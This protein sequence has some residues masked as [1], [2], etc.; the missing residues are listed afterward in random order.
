VDNQAAKLFQLIELPIGVGNFGS[1]YFSAKAND[2]AWS[3]L[4]EVDGYNGMPD[5]PVVHVSLYPSK[6]LT[7]PKW[8][9]SDKWP[10]TAG[11]ESV[12]DGGVLVPSFTSNGAYV[13][14]N[15]LVA[16]IPTSVIT[17]AGS[18]PDVISITLSAGVITG[19]LKSVGGVWT[20]RGGVIAARWSLKDVFRALSTYRDNNGQPICTGTPSYSIAKGAICNDADILVD[21]T[22][23]K[24]APCDALSIG[25]GFN[26]DVALKGP[27]ADA[28]AVTDGC[29]AA[30]DP[31]SDSCP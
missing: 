7:A 9:G 25:L 18:G 2:G 10:V 1:D 3:L 31:A 4:I 12:G 23:P 28:G 26:A 22:Q 29:P 30:T 19:T 21:G 20:L 13:S 8:D 5:D 17:L 6:G 27:I 14:N 24:S 11:S 16:T 15:V